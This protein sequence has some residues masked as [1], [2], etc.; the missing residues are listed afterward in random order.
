MSAFRTIRAKLAVYVVAVVLIALS[1]AYTAVVP[2][3]EDRLVRAEVDELQ[4]QTVAAIATV[5][6]PP[7]AQW[8]TTVAAVLDARVVVYA[9][10]RETRTP[11]PIDDSDAISSDVE[12]DPL[13]RATARDGRARRGTVERNGGRYTE[14]VHPFPQEGAIVL[15]AAPISDSLA[16]VRLIGQ[17]LVVAGALVLL[18]AAALGYAGATLFARRIRRLERAADRIAGGTFDQPVVDRS[19]DELGELAASFDRMRERLAHLERARNE[20][21]SNASHELRTPLFSLAGF[22]ELLSEEELDEGT[23]REFLATARTQVERLT[24]LASELLDLSRL[25]A[26]RLHVEREDVELR[27]VVEILGSEFGRLAETTGHRLVVEE[28]PPVTVVA[29]EQR[30]VQ[31]G[32][33]LLENALRHTPRGTSV[34]VRA[35]A[36]RR[37]GFLEVEDDG[38][39]VPAAHRAYVF[40]RFYRVDGDVASG[41][42][43]GLAI[44]RDLAVVM[45]GRIEL[46]C[47]GDGARFALELPLAAPAETPV[48]SAAPA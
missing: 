30:T 12:N 28:G 5:P 44:A 34:T 36:N 1:V 3:L 41:S 39:G 48:S 17:R 47:D 45:G 4:R 14:V 19:A 21:V 42:G 31:I 23:R 8:V 9:V 46:V 27:G 7:Y 32:R 15:I 33:A 43:L 13:V 37:C 11:F 20:F 2:A 10:N 35:R 18:V 25:D 38:P 22:L 29:D 40:D 26:G 16:T 24:K 6:D